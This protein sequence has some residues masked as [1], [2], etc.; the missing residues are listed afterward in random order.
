MLEKSL[1]DISGTIADM[2]EI[3]QMPSFKQLSWAEDDRAGLDATVQALKEEWI[4]L[5]AIAG[6]TL[7]NHRLQAEGLGVLKM[8]MFDYVRRQ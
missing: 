5:L 1:E 3:T 4:A 7:K 6:C 2:I 8:E